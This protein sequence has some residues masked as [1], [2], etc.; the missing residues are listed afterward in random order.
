L[1][2]NILR[3]YVARIKQKQKTMRRLLLPLILAACNATA[4]HAFYGGHTGVTEKNIREACPAFGTGTYNL[5]SSIANPG[6]TPLVDIFEHD[7]GARCQCTR[8]R[9][10]ER[11]LRCGPTAPAPRG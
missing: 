7:T 10:A 5:S 2:L 1:Q 9:T 3:R 8:L 11:S 4:A 6:T